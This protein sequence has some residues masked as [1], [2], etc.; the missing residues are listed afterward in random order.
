MAAFDDQDYRSLP[1]EQRI[2]VEQQ[3]ANSA[4]S[5]FVSYV[6][7]FIGGVIG[8]HRFYLG[9]PFTAICMII[10]LVSGVITVSAGTG[11][12]LLGLE[13]LILIADLF[14][15][16]IMIAEHKAKLRLQYAKFAPRGHLPM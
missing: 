10:L 3:V 5:A 7:W 16:P 14:L 9:R 2:L 6:L 4:K 8:A 12:I 1:T 11:V 15:I 13:G